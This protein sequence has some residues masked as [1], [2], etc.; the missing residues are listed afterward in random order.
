MPSS[1]TQDQQT[2]LYFA[3]MTV[4][5]WGLYGV[6]LHKGVHSM[7]DPEY[8]RYKAYLFVGLAYFLFAVAAPAIL[9]YFT[10]ANWHFERAGVIWSLVAG[11]VGAF[12]AFGILLA[13]GAKGHPAVVMSIVF[14]GAPILNAAVAIS[15]EGNWGNIR[16]QFIAGIIL[17]I[18]GA[19]IVTLY[20]PPPPRP[21]AHQAVEAV[22]AAD[23]PTGDAAASTAGASSSDDASN[24]AS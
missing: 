15:L 3:L 21:A 8:G 16:W 22:E 13:F 20:K 5:M 2:W 10:N 18:T 7:A 9:L 1:A 14:A 17:A 24:G 11:T 6:L 12:G 19:T 23:A 4:S